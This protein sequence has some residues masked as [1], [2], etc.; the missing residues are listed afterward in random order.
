MIYDS[1]RDCARFSLYKLYKSLIEYVKLVI[2]HL[3]P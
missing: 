3:I 1:G 2:L